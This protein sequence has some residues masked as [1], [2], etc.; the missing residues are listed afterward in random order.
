MELYQL[1]TFVKI[2]EEGSLTKAAELLFTSQPAIS[3]QIK[4]LEEE[5]GVALFDRTS[6]GMQLTAKGRL[7]YTQALDTLNAAAKLKSDAQQLQN[8]LVG[9]IR[10]GVHTDFEFMRIGE[11]HRLLQTEHPRVSPYFT[12]SMS[13]DILPD[14]RR[15]ALDAGFFFGPCRL[16]DLTTW[17]LAEV[18]MRIVAPADWSARVDKASLEDLARLPWVYTSNTCPFFSLTQEL[19]AD[20]DEEPNKVA[21]VDSEDA[22]RELIRAGA[23][24]SM[25]RVDDAA[26]LQANGEAV[27]WYGET[28][29]IMLGFAV[30]G[31]RA[32]EPVISAVQSLI[33]DMWLAPDNVVSSG[34]G[35]SPND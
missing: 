32:A 15:G 3:A 31:Q 18:P 7:L 2:A 23:G 4:A 35:G 13:M 24:L 25:L 20:L 14:I 10:I 22:V 9:E 34:T 21:Y 17:V 30:Q 11:L 26:R 16:A 28:P 12:Q 5:L 8:E 27:C 19:F 33:T 6:R 1:K 29:R